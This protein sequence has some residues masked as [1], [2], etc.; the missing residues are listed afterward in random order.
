MTDRRPE[1]AQAQT[2]KRGTVLERDGKARRVRVKFPDED[3]VAGYWYDVPGQGSSKNANYHMPDEGDEVWVVTDASGEEGFVSGTRFNDVDGSPESDPDVTAHHR[4][5][6][7]VQRHDPATGKYVDTAADQEYG[8]GGQTPSAGV[9]H[10]VHVPFGSS[11][12]MHP[13]ATGSPAIKVS[14]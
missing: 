8:P 14:K 11:A 6:G 5:D 4:R 2:G 13:I 3:G 12:G 7:S 10:M 9:G 1:H